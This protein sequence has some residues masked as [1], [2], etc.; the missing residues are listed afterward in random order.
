MSRKFPLRQETVAVSN[1]GHG[2][3]TWFMHPFGRTGRISAT[4]FWGTVFL[5]PYFGVFCLFV[6]YPVG[7]GLWLG[8]NWASFKTLFA[9]PIY[10]RTVVNTLLLL[11]VGV[12]AKM[13]LALML[14]GFFLQRY[15]FMPLLLLIFILPWAMPAIPAFISVRWMLNSQ[16]G[17][18]NNAIWA[19]AKVDGPNWLTDPILA[20]GSVIVFYVWK[21]LP[22]WTV[23]LIAGRTAIPEDLYEAGRI[24]GA[25]PVQMFRHI[26]FPMIS[27]LYLICTVLSTIWTLGDYNTVRFITGGGP[28]LSTH[29]LATLGIRDAFTLGD[30][31]LGMAAVIS[32][33]PLLVPLVILLI[34]RMNKERVQL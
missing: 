29:V 25:A 6:L 33:L 13:F 20:M 9:D 7:Y 26:T 4:S 12:N 1:D 16:W 32:A 31:S 30:P 2:F 14:S 22:F 19:L 5:L 8:A 18:V 28:T 10:Y 21:W 23:I 3:M 11:L 24:D 15:R 27:S 34:W 17:I